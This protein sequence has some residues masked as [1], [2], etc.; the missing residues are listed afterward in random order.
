MQAIKDIRFYRSTVENVPG[1]SLPEGFYNHE[2]CAVARRIVMKL[3]ENGFSMG[4]FHHLYINFTTCKDEGAFSLSQRGRDPYFP[5]Y[6]YYDVGVSKA[7]YAQLESRVCIEQVIDLVERVLLSFATPDFDEDKIR[8]CVSE[9]VEQ[10]ENML[11]VYKEKQASRNKAVIYLRYLD[12]G[13]YFPLL[14]VFDLNGN[15]IFERD[16]PETNDLYSYGVIQLSSK[17]VT[18]KPRTNSYTENEEPMSFDLL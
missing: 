8:S 9:A 10:D 5:W 17:K 15:I 12:N 6:R 18:I 14:R 13:K 3:Q 16:L 1:N 7:F 4:D 11:M 2:L